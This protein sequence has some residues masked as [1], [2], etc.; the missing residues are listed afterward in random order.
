MSGTPASVPLMGHNEIEFRAERDEQ[1]SNPLWMGFA[2]GATDAA[3]RAAV[4]A[5]TEQ[6][7]TAETVHY[8]VMKQAIRALSERGMKVRMIAATLGM[9]KSTVGR[10]LRSGVDG[11]AVREPETVAAMVRQVWRR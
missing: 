8:L 9:S 3:V 7:A 2:S 11:V 6:V 4:A 10:H 5:A 1:E